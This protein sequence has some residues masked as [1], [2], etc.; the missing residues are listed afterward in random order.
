MP[1]KE[2]KLLGADKVLSIMFDEKLTN[3]CDKNLVEV[4]DRSISLLCRELS[5]YE[6]DGADYII[7]IKSPKIGLLDMG[8]IEEL[9]SLYIL[10]NKSILNI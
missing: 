8:K 5:N 7:K 4:A 9:H 10:Y 3:D 6:M 2:V 1:W